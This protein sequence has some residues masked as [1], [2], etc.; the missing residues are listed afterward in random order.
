MTAIHSRNPTNLSHF[1]QEEDLLG[2]IPPQK[3]IL[4]NFFQN[5][6]NL[7]AGANADINDDDSVANIE[8]YFCFCVFSV[9]ECVCTHV[10][11]EF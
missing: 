2:D 8:V 9:C 5:H 1:T 6:L 7:P 10:L 11:F 4:V 3:A